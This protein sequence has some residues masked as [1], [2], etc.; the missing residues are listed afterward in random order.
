MARLIREKI[1]GLRERARADGTV[2]LW[3]EPSARARELGF[4]PVELDA[5][6]PT[7]SVAQARRINAEVTAAAATG[8]KP[9]RTGTRTVLDLVE[10]Y[11]QSKRFKRQK[12]GTQRSYRGFFNRIVQDWGHRSV[13]SITK[14]QVAEW[15]EDIAATGKLTMAARLV[16]HLSLLMTHAELLGWRAENT[17]PCTRLGGTGAA[18]RDRVC[19]WSEFDAV[20]MAGTTLGWHAAV[21]ATRLALYTG[22]RQ[23]DILGARL[24]QFQLRAVPG[25]VD[26]VTGQAA[27]VLI[28]SHKRSKRG[29]AAHV[30]L[31]PDIA[32]PVQ[33]WI[34]GLPPDAEL[35][36]YDEATGRGYLD[37]NPYLFQKRWQAMRALAAQSIPSVASLM[38]RDLRRTFSVRAR[39]GGATLDDAGDVLGNQLS[40]NQDLRLIYTPAQV[41]PALR[42]VHAIKRPK[43]GSE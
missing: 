23:T 42:A 3:W 36:L 24:D 10:T 29:N 43:A 9:V 25:M 2:R 18:G 8:T 21:L 17:N 5:A 28:W 39:E 35:L 14:P 16:S 38:F 37:G 1:T 32:G 4:D 41:E 13:A 7:W 20:C 33:E 12:P 22:A 15:M 30:P 34:T 27:A 40:T 11:L 19:S 26:A 31:H 6:R